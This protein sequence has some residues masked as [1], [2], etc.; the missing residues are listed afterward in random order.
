MTGRDKFAENQLPSIEAFYNTLEDEPCPPKN[1]D[2]ARE[3]WAHYD[4]KTM[5][6]YH[7]HYLFSDILL[8]PTYMKISE[9]RFT[10]SIV[11]TPSTL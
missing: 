10:S 5:R 8:L 9:I 1:Y 11:S 2:C 6:D 7:D 4:M 3:I